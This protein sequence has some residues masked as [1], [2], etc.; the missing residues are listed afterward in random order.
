MLCTP[1]PCAMHTKT[2]MKPSAPVITRAQEAVMSC[3]HTHGHTR[4]SPDP[5]LWWIQKAVTSHLG[6]LL[7]STLWGSGLGVLGFR[8][9]VTQS[10]R[11][12]TAVIEDAGCTDRVASV[13]ASENRHTS[14]I[15]K[16]VPVG[17]CR[18]SV[19]ICFSRRFQILLEASGSF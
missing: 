3:F 15:P 5:V 11:S 13:V 19:P 10:P 12:C 9:D 2:G 14:R 7:N 18:V 8:G 1:V 6:A 17:E 4:S 16:R